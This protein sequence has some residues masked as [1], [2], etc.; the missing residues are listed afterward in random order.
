MQRVKTTEAVQNPVFINN[1]HKIVF[2]SLRQTYICYH[3]LKICLLARQDV[4][5]LKHT[6]HEDRHDLS[7][8][9]RDELIERADSNWR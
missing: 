5:I 8:I 7:L 2:T 9:K 1:A 4:T 6:Q 3:S